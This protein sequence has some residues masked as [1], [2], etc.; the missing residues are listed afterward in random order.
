MAYPVALPWAI[1][2]RRAAGRRCGA[3]AAGLGLT[4]RE[5]D[6]MK[7][8]GQDQTAG[9]GAQQR[10]CRTSRV[11]VQASAWML[12]PGQRHESAS[13]RES[14]TRA[15]GRG[16]L[17]PP[18]DGRQNPNRCYGGV[19]RRGNFLHRKIFARRSCADRT[20]AVAA[21]GSGGGDGLNT[22]GHRSADPTGG[23]RS[24]TGVRVVGRRP[25][26]LAQARS[27]ARGPSV[28]AT[29]SP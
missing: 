2:L 22:H 8:R 24:Q 15:D 3:R 20:I 4:A 17:V 12:D 21:T 16:W 10:E 7:F 27:V 6:G 5:P 13:P 9:A 18:P 26:H 14:P 29:D 25:R 11:F 19:G 1:S 28:S 23:I